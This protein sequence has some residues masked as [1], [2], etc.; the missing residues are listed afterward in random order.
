MARRGRKKQQGARTPSGQLSRAKKHVQAR[1]DETERQAME[2]ALTTRARRY[3]LSEA[4]AKSVLAG[5]VVGR[6][7][8]SKTLSEAQYQAAVKFFAVRRT[9]LMSI[10]SPDGPQVSAMLANIPKDLNPEDV[11]PEEAKEIDD[12]PEEKKAADARTRW[13]AARE[14]VMNAQMEHRVGN[15]PAAL[16]YLVIRDEYHEHMEGDLRDALDALARLWQFD[17]IYG[18]KEQ[19]A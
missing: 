2:T 5:T 9:Y 19:A 17:R 8:L 16:D 18:D 4:L 6:M 3:G 11:M 13:D 7:R 1:Q 14:A 15:L 12:R 10:E